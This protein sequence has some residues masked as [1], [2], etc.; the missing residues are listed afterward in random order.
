M[1]SPGYVINYKRDHGDWEELQLESKLDSY[2]L[3]NLLCGNR[4]QLYM[5]AYNRIGTGLPC[6]IVHTATRGSGTVPSDSLVHTTSRGAGL[7][8]G[9][10]PLKQPLVH[11]TSRAKVC[12]PFR[13]FLQT[14]LT[15]LRYSPFKQ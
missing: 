2:V 5:T 11:T 12:S 1:C 7:G 3:R 4:Y 14:V 6:D 15:G 8:L 10:N 13:Q 9:Y